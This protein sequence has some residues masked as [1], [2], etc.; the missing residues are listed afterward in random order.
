MEAAG[1]FWAVFFIAER[2]VIM[3]LWLELYALSGRFRKI[4]VF[5]ALAAKRPR[6]WEC[7]HNNDI[8]IIYPTPSKALSK[9][10]L[11]GLFNE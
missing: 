5:L 11:G 9:N 2:E 6:T 1:W 3:L 8:N 4:A 10:I 7:C